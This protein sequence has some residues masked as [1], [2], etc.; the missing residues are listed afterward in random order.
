MKNEVEQK[1]FDEIVEIMTEFA[2]ISIENNYSY[3]QAKMRAI[4]DTHRA[5]NILENAGLTNL[6]GAI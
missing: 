3:S 5:L 4:Y 6:E 2:C 1:A